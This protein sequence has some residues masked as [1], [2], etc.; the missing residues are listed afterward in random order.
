MH[1][2]CC[3]CATIVQLKFLSCFPFIIFPE[4]FAADQRKRENKKKMM[5]CRSDLIVNCRLTKLRPIHHGVSKPIC[6]GQPQFRSNAGL[7]HIYLT[8]QVGHRSKTCLRPVDDQVLFIKTEIDISLYVLNLTILVLAN[9][10]DSAEKLL[11]SS[12]NL[13]KGKLGKISMRSK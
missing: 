10:K 13:R 11:L 4:S 12:E 5:K 6:S 9:R 3:V 7:F 1:I 2:C 8:Q